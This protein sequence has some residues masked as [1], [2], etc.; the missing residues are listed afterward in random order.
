MVIDFF[1]SETKVNASIQGLFAIKDLWRSDYSQKVE[2]G[3]T[4]LHLA[5]YFGAEAIV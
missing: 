4:G 1:E 3:M 5:A 2:K